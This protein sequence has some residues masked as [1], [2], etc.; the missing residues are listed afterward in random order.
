MQRLIPTLA[1]LFL[2]GSVAAE[3]VLTLVPAQIQLHGDVDSH[4]VNVVLTSDG[5]SLGQ[6]EDAELVSS[7]PG[8]AKIKGRK[9]LPVA[10]GEATITATHEGKSAT[11]A[12]KVSGMAAPHRWSFRHDVQPVLA[13]LGCNSG[14]CHGALAGKGGFRLSLRGY[15]NAAD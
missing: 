11:A 7:N 4:R 14:A 9:I 1:L 6:V 15:D 3:D 12:V 5:Q 13:K 8:V 2:G 10:D